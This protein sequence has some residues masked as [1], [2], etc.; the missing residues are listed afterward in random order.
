MRLEDLRNICLGRMIENYELEAVDI[1]SPYLSDTFFDKLGELE[2]QHVY[3]TTDAG[4]SST[5]IE[6]IE[7]SLG[8]IP[9]QLKLAQCEGIVHAKCYLFTWR[10]RRVNRYKRLLLWG[11]C[12]AS[13][14]GFERNAEIFS[15]LLLSKIGQEQQS[16]IIN[17]FSELRGNDN[18]TN[19]IKIKIDALTLKLPRIR[20]FDPEQTTFDLWIQKGRLCHPFPNDPNFRHLKVTLKTRIVSDDSLSTELERNSIGIN[21]QTTIS[22]DYL[23]QAAEEEENEQE[24]NP[25]D[26]YTRIWKSKFFV[27]TVFGFWTSEDCFNNN[28]RDFHRQN[29]ARREMEIDQISQS[30]FLQR[31]EWSENFLSI[32]ESI[33]NS[34]P[35]PSRY[36]HCRDGVLDTERYKELFK[37]QLNRDWTR[38]KDPWFKH[39]YISGY[40]FPE[41]PPMREFSSNWDEF[42]KSLSSSLLFEVNKRNP[43]N[44]LAQAIKGLNIEQTDDSDKFLEMLRNEWDSIQESIRCF[45]CQEE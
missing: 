1:L 9:T 38:S 12:N 8:E 37:K 5:K 23:R 32:L 27:D 24:E 25:D 29:T 20:F 31:K 19:P 28:G 33:S 21:Q 16:A 39:G 40:D 18:G 7:R 2:P 17:Y 15:W 3:V 41:V 30:T 4:C 13:Q 44:R 45:Y 36:F 6:S 42:I 22:Y 35:N 34:I 10:N 43:R 11:S 26:G 14:G